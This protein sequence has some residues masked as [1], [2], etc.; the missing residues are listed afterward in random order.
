MA[1]NEIGQASLIF[2]L[3]AVFLVVT[4]VGTVDHFGFNL[5]E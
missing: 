5:K 3:Y 2:W 4:V 1:R